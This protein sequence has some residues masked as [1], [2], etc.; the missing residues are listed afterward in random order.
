[1]WSVWDLAQ[2]G[3]AISRRRAFSNW[4]SL[5]ANVYMILSYFWKVSKIV[6]IT[7]LIRRQW[8]SV[9]RALSTSK[10]LDRL[11]RLALANDALISKSHKW[12]VCRRDKNTLFWWRL[13]YTAESMKLEYALD[14]YYNGANVNDINAKKNEILHFDLDVKHDSSKWDLPG[15]TRSP[16]SRINSIA[17]SD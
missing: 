1:M 6:W 4:I 13:R 8:L 14:C 11:S 9:S 15:F 3:K 12:S 16:K 10:S 7:P 5:N 2:H 17:G